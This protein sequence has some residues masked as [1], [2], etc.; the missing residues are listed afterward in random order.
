MN[1]LEEPYE[2]MFHTVFYPAGMEEI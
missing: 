2:R 1:L